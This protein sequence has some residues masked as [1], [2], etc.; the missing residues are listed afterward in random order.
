[1]S[2]K[3]CREFKFCKYYAD[4]TIEVFGNESGTPRIT[5]VM[6]APD[7][8]TKDGIERERRYTEAITGITL[9][10]YFIESQKFIKN[11]AFDK[12]GQKTTLEI[13]YRPCTNK[14]E[15]EQVY[16]KIITL[17]GMEPV[18]GVEVGVVPE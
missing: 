16:K 3:I 10:G 6:P 18:N 8:N 2:D 11:K 4:G 9:Q 1:M 12:K 14:S 15:I 5:G 17:L 13:V 7:V